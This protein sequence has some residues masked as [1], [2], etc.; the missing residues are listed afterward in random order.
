V[1]F[2]SGHQL[3]RALYEATVAPLMQS[4]FPD[5]PYAA[6]LIGAGSDVLGYDTERSMDHDWG[7]RLNLILE[8][9]DV[10]RL[11]DDLLDLVEQRLPDTVL[12]VPIEQQ[13]AAQVPGGEVAFH[14]SV[15]KVRRHGVM[16]QSP[17]EILARTTAIEDI[18]RLD[19]AEWLA[20]PQQALLEFTA[21]PVFRDDIGTLTAMRDALAW[22][23]DDVWYALMA[24]QWQ[25]LAQVE[26]FIGRTGEI[27]DDVGSNMIAVSMLHDVMRLVLL[28]NR[29]YAPYAKWL[30]SAFARL[31][32]VSRLLSTMDAVRF[33]RGWQEREAAILDVLMEVGRRHD[34]LGI[35]APVGAVPQLFFE[36]PYRVLFVERFA[37][38]LNDAIQSEEVRRLPRDIGSIDTVT[39]STRALGNRGFRQ[40]FASWLRMSSNVEPDEVT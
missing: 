4:T 20:T 35:T 2:V 12:G 26:P 8:E 15:G 19:V 31:P 9:D 6:A 23:P 37:D 3:G 38:A 13:G 34:A 21:G 1:G 36:R 28:Q 14:N 33:A 30:G 32:D 25:R 27:G 18:Q 10:R 40:A 29:H 16:V 24:A 17:G 22:Y 11:R 7:P 39:D 5:V